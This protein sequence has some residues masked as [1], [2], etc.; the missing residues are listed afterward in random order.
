[1]RC[2]TCE[3]REREMEQLADVCVCVCARV[4]ILDHSARPAAV[5]FM[6]SAMIMSCGGKIFRLFLFFFFFYHAVTVVKLHYLL[7]RKSP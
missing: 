4:F 2:G 1:M 5:L 7:A 3:E 6:P